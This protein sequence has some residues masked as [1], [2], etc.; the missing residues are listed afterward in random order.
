MKR[1]HYFLMF[2]VLLAQVDDTWVATFV[3]TS[4]PLSQ[5]DDDDECTPSQLRTVG[6]ESSARQTPIF[7][8]LKRQTADFS[9]VREGVPSAW[10]LTRPF[11][12]SPLYIFMSLQI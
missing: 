5:V 2:L 12:P 10:N 11:A 8:S 3:S 9:V 6:E 7:N 1:S 4:A